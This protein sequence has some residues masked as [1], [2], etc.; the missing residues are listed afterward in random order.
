M[1]YP[2]WRFM[3]CDLGSNGGGHPFSLLQLLHSENGVAAWL[4][5]VEGLAAW[6]HGINMSFVA[7]NGKFGPQKEGAV[8]LAVGRI[9]QLEFSAEEEEFKHP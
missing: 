4:G 7:L 5:S 6:G 9:T 3:L 8:L 2:Q 1:P